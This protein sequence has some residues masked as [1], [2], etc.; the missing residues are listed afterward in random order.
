MKLRSGIPFKPRHSM[1]KASIFL[2]LSLLLLAGCKK[3]EGNGPYDLQIKGVNLKSV[4]A[5]PVGT[6]GNPDVKTSGHDF[7]FDAYPIP[8]TNQF[9]FY[10]HVTAGNGITAKAKLVSAL[11]QGAPPL[12]NI[13]NGNMAGVV[14]REMDASLTGNSQFTMNT[15]DLPQ[16]FYRLYLEL[17]NGEMYW[18]NIWIAR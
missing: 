6:L 5:V 10:I 3:N 2:A 7:T 16:G 12:T 9:S 18:D 14:V 8:C 13:E 15:A 17:S 1:K 11:Y 4:D